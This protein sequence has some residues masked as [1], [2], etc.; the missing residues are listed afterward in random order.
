[1]VKLAKGMNVGPKAAGVGTAWLGNSPA[2]GFGDGKLV[3]G[4]KAY[5]PHQGGILS[6]T[7]ASQSGLIVTCGEEGAV[8]GTDINGHSTRLFHD[9]KA[10]LDALAFHNSIQKLAICA[11]RDVIV[12]DLNEGAKSPRR[13]QP[14]RAPTSLAFS[15]DGTFL[16]IGHSGG[17]SLFKVAHPEAVW[18]EFPC[19]GGPLSVALDQSGDFLF[20]GLSEPAL[21]GWRLSDGQGFRMGGY[22]GKP[23]QLVWSTNGKALLTT[24][25]PAL[26][27][28]PMT[29][30]DGQT[31]TGPMGQ[32][33]GVYRPRLGMMTAVATAG[34]Y[35][36]T[37]WSDGGVDLV[38]L[39]DASSRHIGGPRPPKDIDKDPRALTT[40]IVSLAFRH[41]GKQVS[42][43]SETGSYG[44]AAIQ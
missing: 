21:A 33:A 20:A 9:P 30:K 7:L 44:T 5:Y 38:N 37:G 34:D 29:A 28:W 39:L 24:G 32:A 2:F 6:L 16:A 11:G 10:W 35:A 18:H 27:V 19:T 31:I 1:M 41:D 17:V 15:G 23:R 42:W 26:L 43:I 4:G 3:L 40:N 14:A 8:M 22:P 36:A 13:L 25:G 12:I